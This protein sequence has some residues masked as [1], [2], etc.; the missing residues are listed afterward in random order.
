MSFAAMRD[1][2][3]TR[4]QT[5]SGLTVYRSEVNAVN[6]FPSAVV[7]VD[8]IDYPLSVGGHAFEA[9]FRI[10]VF[11]DAEPYEK[12]LIDLDPYLASTGTSSIRT[13]IYGDRNLGTAADGVLVSA[14]ENVGVRRLGDADVAGADV[15]VTVVKTL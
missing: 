14:A 5:I 7:R 6:T 4:L 3:V 13:A 11:V 9:T 8:R 15:L 2:L 10:S 1:G 12:A